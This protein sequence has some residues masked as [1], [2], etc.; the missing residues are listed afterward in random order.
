[1]RYY[2]QSNYRK[3]KQHQHYDKVLHWTKLISIT[4]AA[5]IIVQVTGLI[6]GILIIRLLP[7][8]EYAYYTIANTMLSTMTILA[9]GGISTGVMAEGGKVWNDKLKLGAV[10]N[11]GLFLRKK[12]AIY[13]LLVTLP[14]LIFLLLKQNAPLITVAFIILAII[15][16]F[17]AALSDSLLETILKLHQAI[18][19]LQRN[20]VVV[21][22][23]RLALSGIF[24]LIFPFTALVLLG[25]GI[26]RV[27]GNIRLKK[28]ALNYTEGAVSKDLE[29]EK[30]ILNIVKRT[31]P[32]AIY[33]CLSGQITIWL[34]TLFGTVNSIASLGALTRLTVFLNMFTVLFSTI[35]IPRFAKLENSYRVLM[36]ALMQ[37]MFIVILVCMAA[38]TITWLADDSIL[39]IL[40]P[41]YRNLNHE[42]LLSI[43]ISC[44]NMISGLFFTLSSSKG[45]VIN[46]ILLIGGN[47]FSI[48]L[49][50][51]LF[52]V[53]NLYGIL[54]FQLFIAI[55]PILLNGGFCLKRILDV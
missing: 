12:F 20:Q 40:G 16:A 15:P 35:F 22:I 30:N 17:L 39:C 54:L 24:A 1:M 31:L 11:T 18:K 26:P 29:V 14:I 46:P 10:L 3:I 4:G 38:I 5:Q 36:V 23:F 27:L 49:G 28:I 44:M 7:T 47:I 37:F 48:I 6:T 19:P 8:K 32:G 9:D 55:A 50:V 41:E 2:I 52:N 43:I 51:M 45:W 42:L 34:L 13:S 53:S 33:Y 25:N 21:S